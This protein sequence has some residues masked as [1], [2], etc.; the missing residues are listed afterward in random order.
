MPYSNDVLR[1]GATVT[2]IDYAKNP[3][4][5][6]L[7][8]LQVLDKVIAYAGTKGLRVILDRHRPDSNGQSE[9]W[10]TATTPETTWIAD[11]K[12]LA[13]RYRGVPTVIGADLH[14]E[15]RNNK[16]ATSGSCWGGGDQARGWRLAAERAGNAILAVNPDW[17]IIVEGVDS[18]SEVEPGWWG[19]NLSLA[20]DLPV[21]LSGKNTLVYSAHEC[22]TS[23][24]RQP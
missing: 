23:V 7:S 21:R 18:T 16:S 3:D 9:L 17:L 13:A 14:N 1:P 10:Y 6:G 11:W 19:G 15:P 20:D 22:A 5:K 4:L 24:F 8:P 12:A 2:G